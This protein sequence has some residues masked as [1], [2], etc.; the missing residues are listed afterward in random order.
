MPSVLCWGRARRRRISRIAT[1]RWLRG[2]QF[3]TVLL[4][5]VALVCA[6]AIVAIVGRFGGVRW[7]GL[8]VVAVVGL[9]VVHVSWTCGPACAVEGLTTGLAAAARCETTGG[10][11]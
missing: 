10:E 3:D 2:L 6:I 11:C 5:I 4:L 7:C 1:V 9:R 8:L